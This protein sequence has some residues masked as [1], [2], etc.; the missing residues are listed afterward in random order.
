MLIEL[1]HVSKQWA[2]NQ[3]LCDINESFEQGKVHGII[4]RNGSGKTVL[5]K[6][7]CGLTPVEG[8]VLVNGLRIGHD[9]ETPISLGAIINAP[10]FI[11]S[12]SGLSNLKLLAGIRGKVNKK[13]LSDLMQH[14]GLSPT[15]RKH[16]GKYS[17]GM[18]QRLAIAQA[19]MDY[20]T[21]LILD[22]AFNGL[23][24]S[25]V[26]DMRNLILDQK[27]RGATILMS[28]HNPLD[29]EVLCDCVYEMDAGQ[30]V[31]RI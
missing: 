27:K 11:P 3:V 1:R 28:S 12:M 5:F 16:V 13:Y 6:A 4:G 17:M 23:D 31:R 14:V 20:P 9:I 8:E 10:S 18:R 2:G 29:I 30:L 26:V 25:G 7:I 15:N 24:N 22:E 19:I 21:L